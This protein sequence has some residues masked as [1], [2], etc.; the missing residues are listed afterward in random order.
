MWWLAVYQDYLGGP[1]YQGSA[2]RSAEAAEAAK[3]KRRIDPYWAG[4]YWSVV[5]VTR[6]PRRETVED[7]ICGEE[8]R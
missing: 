6:L 2:H 3:I 1:M 7:V 5:R 8:E 4:Y